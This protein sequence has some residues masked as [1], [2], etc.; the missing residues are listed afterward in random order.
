MEIPLK[1]NLCFSTLALDK[2]DDCRDQRRAM[3]EENFNEMRQ[4]VRIFF[5]ECTNELL[6]NTFSERVSGWVV[7]RKWEVVYCLKKHFVTV[8]V[9]V[10]RRMKICGSLVERESDSVCAV[11][12]G[13]CTVCLRETAGCLQ[14]VHEITGGFRSCI[15]RRSLRFI[16]H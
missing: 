1:L 3:K 6:R 12:T 10:P 4:R 13:I 14:W 7:R 9:S 15:F 2:E 8:H 16:E 5:F 11:C